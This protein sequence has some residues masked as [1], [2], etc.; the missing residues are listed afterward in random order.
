MKQTIFVLLIFGNILAANYAY[1]QSA[2]GGGEFYVEETFFPVYVKKNDAESYAGGSVSKNIPTESGLGVDL[3]TTLGYVAWSQVLFGVTFNYYSVSTS[4]P[5]TPD[6]EGLTTKTAKMDFGPTV[7]YLLGSW[8]FMFTYFVYATKKY[9]ET[10]TDPTT[11][12]VD[13]DN[14]YDNT[15]GTGFQLALSYGLNLGSSWTIGPTLVYRDV[16]YGKQALSTP[17]GTPYPATSTS[18]PGTAPIDAQLQ[19]MVTVVYRF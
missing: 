15:N 17:T 7:G 9:Q 18:G 12:V 10:Y 4:R 5:R 16:H 6:Y 13:T 8:R 1:A 19:P 14:T 2:Q 3:R 11:G